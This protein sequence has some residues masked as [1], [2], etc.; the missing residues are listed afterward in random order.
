MDC[1][2]HQ[3]ITSMF[4]WCQQMLQSIRRNLSL[5]IFAMLAMPRRHVCRGWLSLRVMGPRGGW[6]GVTGAAAWYGRQYTWG[7]TD[8]PPPP[9]TRIQVPPSP[10]PPASHPPIISADTKLFHRQASR[11]LRHAGGREAVWRLVG[12]GGAD[13]PDYVWNLKQTII[14]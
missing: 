9:P 4:T 12:G 14:D 7:R 2:L 6:G 10:P 5:G 3:D 13:A 11:I 1:R 8:L